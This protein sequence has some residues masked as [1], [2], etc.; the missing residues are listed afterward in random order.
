M[1]VAKNNDVDAEFREKCLRLLIEIK[2]EHC[3]EALESMLSAS[4]TRLQL[5]SIQLLGDVQN[6]K[7]GPLLLKQ[8]NKPLGGS[9]KIKERL[10]TKEQQAS[11]PDPRFLSEDLQ[12]E[13]SLQNQFLAETLLALGKQQSKKTIPYLLQGLEQ[14]RLS[15]LLF[16][17][18]GLGHLKATEALEP[19]CAIV[20]DRAGRYK[21]RGDSNIGQNR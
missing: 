11:D 14:K 10:R 12:K 8:L 2:S 19:L 20:S 15:Y 18:S 21:E 3:F 1:F 4:E 5:L 9:A 7:C 17:I 16:S 6:K 13:E